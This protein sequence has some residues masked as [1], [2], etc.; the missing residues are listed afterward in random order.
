MTP[1]YD[2][3]KARRAVFGVSYGLEYA[4]WFAP[5]GM[6]PVEELAGSRKLVEVLFAPELQEA[7]RRRVCRFGP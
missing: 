4:L 6:Q 1:V 3:L 2:R 7:C 5:D